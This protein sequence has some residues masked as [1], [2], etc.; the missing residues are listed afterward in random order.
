MA[1]IFIT[2]SSD[3]LG[4]NAARLL[5][6]QGHRVTLH[7]R[8]ERR[9]RDARQQ[10]TAAEGVVVGDVST[11]AAMRSVAEQANASGRFDAVIHNV[12]IGYREPVRVE[13]E[14]GIERLFA[15]NVLAPY[16]LT[17][18][19]TPPERLMYLSSGMHRGGRSGV[20]TARRPTPPASCSTR[21]WRSRSRGAGRTCSRMRSSPAGWRPRWV[22][23]ARR[24]ISRK[25]TSRRPGSRSAT[26]QRPR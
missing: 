5:A 8:S 2:G 6:E 10:L 15:I 20:G 7:A 14:D 16:V 19:L 22:A 1:R 23:S 11:L 18:L 4:L 21:C 9:A 13:T 25:A 26:I 3:G 12:A 17:A 24:T